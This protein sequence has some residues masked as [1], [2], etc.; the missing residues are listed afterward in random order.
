MA[1][2]C[3]KGPGQIFRYDMGDHIDVQQDTWSQR[4]DFVVNHVQVNL[5]R[6][7]AMT[8]NMANQGI[9]LTDPVAVINLKVS[10]LYVVV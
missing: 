1:G 9:E 10:K 8:W 6:L 5:P 7:K 4:F 3:A 2:R